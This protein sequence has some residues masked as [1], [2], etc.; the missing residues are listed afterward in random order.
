MDGRR[1]PTIL[2]V[3]GWRFYFYENEGNEPMHVHAVKGDADCKYWI[4]A[5]RFD[6]EEEFEYICSP[7][8]RRDVRRIIFTHFDEICAAWRG[9]FGGADVH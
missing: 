6:I 3:Q 8:L 2:M 4:Y 1:M 9:R 5:D 7:R